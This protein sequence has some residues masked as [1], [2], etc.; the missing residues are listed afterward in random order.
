VLVLLWRAVPDRGMQPFTI[1]PDQPLEY[2]SP[3]LI[4]CSIM[5]IINEFS[6]K[7]S[8]ETLRHS[9]VVRITHSP[10]RLG[11]MQILAEKPVVIAGVGGSV[12]RINPNSA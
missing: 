3:G 6:F 1:I 12:V 11:D 5:H 10:H 4:F 8:P 7:R 9:I 2:R